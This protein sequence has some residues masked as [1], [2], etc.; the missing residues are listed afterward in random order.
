MSRQGIDDFGIIEFTG[1][2]AGR[3]KD[4]ESIVAWAASV[5]SIASGSSMDVSIGDGVYTQSSSRW[6]SPFTLALLG[7]V[8]DSSGWT[9]F[10]LLRRSDNL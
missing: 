4:V 9:K 8:I 10:S 1:T 3:Y 5:Y 7:S 2:R 6:P